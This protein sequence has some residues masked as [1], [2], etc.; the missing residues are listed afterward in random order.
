VKEA[1]EDNGGNEWSFSSTQFEK[2]KL[3]GVSYT[4]DTKNVV[5]VDRKFLMEKATERLHR[6]L[7]IC[8]E[9]YDNVD[10]SDCTSSRFI[11]HTKY[12]YFLCHE[13][14]GEDDWTSNDDIFWAHFFLGSRSAF[15]FRSSS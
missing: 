5:A 8:H 9:T 13:L 6:L 3:C 1:V 10:E 14:Y 2:C 15:A 4:G 7:D 12:V 11:H